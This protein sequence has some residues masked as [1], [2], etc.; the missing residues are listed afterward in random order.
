MGW[1]IMNPKTRKLILRPLLAV[2]VLVGLY[3]AYQV[4]TDNLH[5]VI[6][7]ELYRSARPSLG[8]IDK[9]HERY[10]IKTIINLMGPHPK[11]DWYQAENAAAKAKGIRM[12]D[13]KM[14]PDR[15]VSAEEVGEILDILSDAEKPILVHCRSGADRTGLVSALYVAGIA[16]GSEL[17][18]EFQLTPFFGHLPLPFLSTFAMD[19]S[20]E[21]A[22]PR[23]GFPD[24]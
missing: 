22:E 3:A 5:T 2:L 15:D 10:G 7:G 6:P 1:G 24:S 23:L 21:S 17:F 9:W 14:S 4:S 16:G 8:N 13:Y 19:R 18:A 12:I 11:H 20:F